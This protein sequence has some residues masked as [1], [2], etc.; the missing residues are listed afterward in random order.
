MRL[1][2]PARRGPVLEFED[3]L[4]AVI[5]DVVRLG[6]ADVQAK[7][8]L[9]L[10][11][12]AVLRVRR[13]DDA[14]VDL[15]ADGRGGVPLVFGRDLPRRRVADLHLGAALVDLLDV[16]MRPRPVHEG[17]LLAHGV[18]LDLEGHVLR[19]GIGVSRDHDCLRVAHLDIG[20]RHALDW[21]AVRPVARGDL[22]GVGVAVVVMAGVVCRE[23]SDV[24]RFALGGLHLLGVLL[25]A[26]TDLL[27]QVL[28]QGLGLRDLLH[29]VMR[30]E[31]LHEVVLGL[32]DVLEVELVR[33]AAQLCR[34]LGFQFLD[35]LRLF[36]LGGVRRRA[37]GLGAALGAGLRRRALPFL[38]LLLTVIGGLLLLG[39]AA[40]G[41]GQGGGHRHRGEG[42]GRGVTR[43]G[44]GCLR[45]WVM[46][47][48]PRL[49][50]A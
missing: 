19:L 50:S 28:R 6:R 29:G 33:D 12:P 27:G 26:A 40:G 10:A 18:L 46:T 30:A 49:H 24:E 2:L 38:F 14:A 45:W 17:E 31:D 23:H 13:Q 36:R 21:I 42:P 7:E 5:E 9:A 48:E 15:A 32:L 43:D 3:G 47:K 25:G 4:R 37:G 1:L 34:D 20:Q 11:G 39:G 41:Q 22:G 8:H 16:R 35:Q 44:H